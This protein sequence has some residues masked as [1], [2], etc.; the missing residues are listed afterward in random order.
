MTKRPPQGRGSGGRVTPSAKATEAAKA[1]AEAEAAPKGKGRLL[2][3]SK[4]RAA[5]PAAPSAA[6]AT[7][8]ARSSSSSKADRE[9]AGAVAVGE[10]PV[11]P[12][13]EATDDGAPVWGMGEVALWWFL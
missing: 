2:R 10:P 1:A 11:P 8:A 3:S 7:A 6:P 13:S 5:A 4:E 12:G 9:V